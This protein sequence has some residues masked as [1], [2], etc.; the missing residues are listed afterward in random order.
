[1]SDVID[2]ERL[3][4]RP[5]AGVVLV[6]RE[7]LVFMGKRKKDKKLLDS[8][9]LWQMPQGGIDEGEEPEKAALRELYEETSVRSVEL[10]RLSEQWFTYDL[11]EELIGVAWKGKYRGQK[12]KWALCLLTGDDSEIDVLN[13]PQGHKPEFAKW[14][15]VKPAETLA[16]V[17][18]FKQEI[19]RQI[20]ATFREDFLAR[21][22][23]DPTC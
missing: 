7:G 14:A 3:P 19:Y 2:K 11:P 16:K 17:V 13:P 23:P 20:F 21:N 9:T 1:M 6:N 15:W 22:W 5:C 12:Q 4:Y 18:P 8:Q 10:I